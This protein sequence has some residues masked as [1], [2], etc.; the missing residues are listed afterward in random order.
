MNS[1]LHSVTISDQEII[2]TYKYNENY[3]SKHVLTMITGVLFV[4]MI[5]IFYQNIF[6]N[7]LWLNCI[8]S[9]LLLLILLIFINFVNSGLC[10]LLFKFFGNNLESET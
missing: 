5:I 8:I 10:F 4:G 6:N 9:I 7:E 2:T 3:T 1:F